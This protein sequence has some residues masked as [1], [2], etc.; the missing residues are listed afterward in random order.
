MATT[1]AIP[2]FCLSI[3][4][5]VK[6][7]LQCMPNKKSP[8]SPHHLLSMY[9]LLK[10]ENSNVRD[11]RTLAICTLAY[12]GFLRFSEVSVLKRDDIDIKDAYMRLFLE[13]SK[14]DATGYTLAN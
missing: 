13:Q 6:R 4:E 11:L 1:F 7:A 12:V 8:L 10:G 2:F 14:T 3:Y 5:G 9:N